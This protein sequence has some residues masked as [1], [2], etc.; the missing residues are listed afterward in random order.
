MATA[1]SLDTPDRTLTPDHAR[2]EFVTVDGATFMRATHQPG[3]RWSTH[4]KPQTQNE[5]CQVPH[6]GV[7]LSGRMHFVMDDG[8]ELEVGPGDAH[9]VGPGHDAW[10]VGDEPCVILNYV[11]GA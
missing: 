6:T 2:M 3:W 11:A 8:Q 1:K 5:S 10:V 7:V 4:L 9:S